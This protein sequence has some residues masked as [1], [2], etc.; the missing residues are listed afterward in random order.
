MKMGACR[1]SQ[2]LLETFFKNV[3]TG[4]PIAILEPSINAVE[5]VAVRT[6]GRRKLGYK[7]VGDRDSGDP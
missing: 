5:N 2:H 7:K 6:R 3:V 4:L 1:E